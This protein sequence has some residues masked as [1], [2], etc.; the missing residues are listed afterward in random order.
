MGAEQLYK[1]GMTE[2]ALNHKAANTTGINITVAVF[3]LISGR[4]RFG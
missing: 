4:D 3:L 2:P 1:L